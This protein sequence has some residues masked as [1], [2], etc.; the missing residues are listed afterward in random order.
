MGIYR[1]IVI[2]FIMVVAGCTASP[3][4]QRPDEYY[5]MNA[6]A[7]LTDD[8][9]SLFKGDESVI[10]DEDVRRILDYRYTFPK[11]SRIAILPLGQRAWWSSWSDEFAK[12]NEEK[13][14]AFVNALRSSK[15]VY[16]A[17]FLPSI[18]VPGKRTIPYLREVAARYQADL[19]LIYRTDCKTFE[20][21]RIFSPNETRAYCT[22]ESALLDTRTGIIPFT[23]VNTET[24][25]AK[26]SS[27]DRNF[28]ETIH[29]AQINAIGKALLGSAQGLVAYIEADKT[30]I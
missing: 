30:K 6:E 14:Q 2:A 12:M 23:S 18:L 29:R 26:V 16:D 17:S 7:P 13:E 24:F 21:Y 22:I 28:S 5:T 4:V 1:I 27:E 3:T 10:A 20:E 25:D 8:A 15:R 9:N 11:V 19:L